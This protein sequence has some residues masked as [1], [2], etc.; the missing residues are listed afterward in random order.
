[1]PKM[2][3]EEVVPTTRDLATRKC[4]S[5]GNFEIYREG[6]GI[7]PECLNGLY[8]TPTK[9]KTVLDHYY[10]IQGIQN[11]ANKI[12]NE[13]RSIHPLDHATYDDDIK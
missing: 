2:I 6:G 7:V 11:E 3:K 4:D 12:K 10:E 8:T 13:M 5:Y 9:A 1:M